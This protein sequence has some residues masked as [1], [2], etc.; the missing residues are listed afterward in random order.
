M[1]H[2]EFQI[3]APNNKGLPKGDLEFHGNAHGAN[4]QR[5]LVSRAATDAQNWIEWAELEQ[6]SCQRNNTDQ[7]PHGFGADE[8]HCQK[9][10]TNNDAKGAVKAANICRHTKL[11]FLNSDQFIPH[12]LWIVR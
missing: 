4:S 1:E 5:E 7:A 6:T 10:N 12:S 11:H 2:F 8:D 9:S 3:S